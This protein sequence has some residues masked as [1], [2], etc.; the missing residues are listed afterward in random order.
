MGTQKKNLLAAYCSSLLSRLIS[1]VSLLCDSDLRDAQRDADACTKRV[2]HEGFGFLSKLLPQLGKAIDRSLSTG[3]L[4]VPAGFRTCRNSKIP[5]FCRGIFRRIY[6]EDGSLKPESRIS[7]GFE[8]LR[9]LRQI[10]Y[11][12][13]KVEMALH[14]SDI[15]K[16]IRSFVDV[17]RGLPTQ[18]VLTEVVMGAALLLEK[19]LRH[20]DPREI[21]PGHGPGAVATGEKLWDKWSFKRRYLPLD[22]YYPAKDYLVIGGPREL[23]DRLEW[24]R[25]LTPKDRGVAK[26]IAVPKDSRGP[27]LISA[28]PLEYQFFQ[29]GLGRALTLYVEQH[30]LTKGLVNFTRQS[31][32]QEMAT[33]A[34]K[35]GEW[36]TIDLKDA[37]DRVSLA[38]V[39]AIFP[40]HVLE[41]LEATRTSATSL[42]NGE[43]VEFKK[44]AP[45]GS[46]LCF[47]V[48]ALTFWALTT[49]WLQIKTSPGSCDCLIPVQQDGAVEKVAE[50]S[51]KTVRS[52]RDE[53]ISKFTNRVERESILPPLLVHIDDAPG[54]SL[55]VV[56]ESRLE[57]TGDS[58]SSGTH[59]P[60]D[61]LS[62]RGSVDQIGT[63]P[64]AE[65]S[66]EIQCV[67]PVPLTPLPSEVGSGFSTR[68]EV[69]WA[70]DAYTVHGYR[71]ASRDAIRDRATAGCMGRLVLE[72]P[73]KILRQCCF[74][75]GDDIVIPVEFA[76]EYPRMLEA[77]GLLVNED[78][79]F[80]TGLFRESCGVDVYGGHDVTPV[81]LRHPIWELDDFD[82]GSVLFPHAVSFVNSL[83]MRGYWNTMAFALQH[84]ES[85]TGPVPYGTA[86]SGFPCLQ[87]ES[88]LACSTLNRVCGLATR[89][90][91]KN[92]QRWE[93]KVRVVKTRTREFSAF[94]GWARLMRSLLAQTEE[95]TTWRVRNWTHL[96]W[97]WRPI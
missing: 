44:F 24:Y 21:V 51:L 93:F 63:A 48:E 33:F 35:T 56:L 64:D 49:S 85:I 29:Q 71:A 20:F 10:C 52:I 77:V 75:Y 41:A 43:I 1:D 57:P 55:L 19:L 36:A 26:L 65:R 17:D 18:V 67:A 32:N 74:V 30:P 61:A 86:E 8:A 89:R 53:G 28:E 5:V 40:D 4:E 60:M 11:L 76:S 83:Y 73:K 16:S 2:H 7:S 54:D 59:R 23:V 45:M 6:G 84:I 27:R 82:Q 94:D 12:Y 42:P 47:P 80:S 87:L 79:S 62:E 15:N 81:K 68:V 69:D 97:S 90:W 78:K 14:D 34:S 58:L 91:N 72:E 31:V 66:T 37:S 46:A 3:V 38:L 22:S 88:A 9:G 96:T 50:G 39:R 13:Y 70:F 25:S 95:P 92:L